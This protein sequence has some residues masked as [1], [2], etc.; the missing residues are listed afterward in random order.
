MYF[1]RRL[2]INQSLLPGFLCV[3]R[4]SNTFFLFF[5]VWSFC[6]FCFLSHGIMGDSGQT[7]E[8]A[9]E[10]NADQPVKY[11]KR[12]VG[13]MGFLGILTLSTELKYPFMFESHGELWGWPPVIV[14]CMIWICLGMGFLWIEI[15]DEGDYLLVRS[16]PWGWSWM[17]CGKEKIKYSEIR[18]YSISRMCWFPG[19]GQCCSGVT[20][21]DLSSLPLSESL[22]SSAFVHRVFPL[23]LTPFGFTI[24]NL[25][26][27]EQIRLMNQCSLCC[28]PSWCGPA[29]TLNPDAR[30]RCC[31]QKTIRLT[32]NERMFLQ[33]AADSD[34]CCVEKLCLEHCCGA[35]CDENCMGGPRGGG[36]CFAICCNTCG[37]NLCAMDTM[38]ISTE[39]PDGLID[40]LNRKTG[41]TVLL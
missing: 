28:Q 7:A 10:N 27:F 34:D 23:T 2:S 32:V 29:G 17:G 41:K 5:G 24:V 15:S 12:H 3:F 38:Y 19:P 6:C 8:V 13:L 14:M 35:K 31:R 16:G 26:H 4:N 30:C 11:R 40:L 36:C 39:D 20:I 33:D 21:P 22:S 25:D 9:I 18:D 37:A 1:W